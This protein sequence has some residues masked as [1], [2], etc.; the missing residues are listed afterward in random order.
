MTRRQRKFTVALAVTLCVTALHG[1]PSA[2]SPSGEELRAKAIRLPDIVAALAIS[3]GSRVADIGAGEGFFTVRLAKK[4]GPDG[5]VFA[6]DVD[7]KNAIPKLKE[8]VK[9]ESL[10][11][12]SVI[13]SE[14][15]DPKLAT[16]VIDAAL[17]VIV[18]HEVEPYKDMLGH[19]LGAL[20]PGGRFVIVDNMPHKT[21]SRPRADQMKNHVLSPEL[22]EAEL[23]AAGFEV[24]SR[25]DDFVDRPDEED[26]KWMI[27]SRR[28][29]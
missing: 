6:I 12:V 26:A 5:H 18:Y 24:T 15:G 25:Q 8:L 29:K 2:G 16:E 11:N 22:T 1:Q 13:L 19:I 17:M 9:K 20:K 28:P 21:R 10:G 3:P 14:P 7:D 23:K 27:V 4:V